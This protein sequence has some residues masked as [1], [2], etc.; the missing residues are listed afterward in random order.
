MCPE[1]ERGEHTGE[2]CWW[3]PQGFSFL[4]LTVL[5][6]STLQRSSQHQPFSCS[7]PSSQHE[8]CSLSLF[9]YAI[10][11]LTPLSSF[12]LLHFALRLRIFFLFFFS[13]SFIT[14]FFYYL[15]QEASLWIPQSCIPQSWPVPSLVSVTET[16]SHCIANAYLSTPVLEMGKEA[17]T[18]H[19][20]KYL[21]QCLAKS[22]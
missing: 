19:C 14:Q 15:V 20:S 11:S 5:Y 18:I 12:P 4:L 3:L 16:V 7:C 8:I 9:T 10:L 6:R 17:F 1:E 21:A 22:Q 2:Q 13:S